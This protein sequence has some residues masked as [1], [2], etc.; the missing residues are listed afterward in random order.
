M[1]TSDALLADVEKRLRK[2]KIGYTAAIG[3]AAVTRWNEDAYEVESW[4]RK[5]LTT[6]QAARKIVEYYL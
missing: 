4:S 6:L 2:L 1:N 3:T 5:T